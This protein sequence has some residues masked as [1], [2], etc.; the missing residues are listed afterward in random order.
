ME[1]VSANAKEVATGIVRGAFEFQGQKCSAASRAYIPSNL[2]DEVKKYL[3]EDLKTFKMGGTEDF[4]KHVVG[5]ADGHGVDG[6]A[7]FFQ[8]RAE[9]GEMRHARKLAVGLGEIA[10]VDIAQADK[11]HRRMLADIVQ[12]AETLP[13][14][15]DGG[16][17]HAAVWARGAQD[18]GK[19][20]D[21]TGD[22][23]LLQKSAARKS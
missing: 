23:R 5:D 14:D 9:V 1:P 10:A 16:N 3:L 18:R 20:E 15:A 17:L 11:S 12:V 8:H 7:E 19:A 6:V 13:G 22:G 2:W 21:G 4:G